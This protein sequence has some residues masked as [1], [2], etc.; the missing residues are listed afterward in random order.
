MIKNS[1]YA[2]ISHRDTTPAQ[3]G[4]SLRQVD[5][6]GYK[7]IGDW[8]DHYGWH[9]LDS[10]FTLQIDF[11]GVSLEKLIEIR[12]QLGHAYFPEKVCAYLGQ[13]FS[14]PIQR[15]VVSCLY[16]ENDQ[17]LKVNDDLKALHQI[18]EGYVALTVTTG[19]LQFMLWEA[20]GLISKVT[21]KAN[22]VTIIANSPGATV[23][24]GNKKNIVKRN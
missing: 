8:M 23:I 14:Q 9:L 20:R 24:Q 7:A 2:V 10:E 5:L 6:N 21:S 11:T 18:N 12:L 1:T 4:N 3:V 17:L 19:E 16:M 22:S 15:G 13:Y